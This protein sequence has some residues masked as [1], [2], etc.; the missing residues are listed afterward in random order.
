[1]SQTNNSSSNLEPNLWS[2]SLLVKDEGG[3]IHPWHQA[4]INPGTDLILSPVFQPAKVLLNDKFLAVEKS[5]HAKSPARHAFHP[6][7]EAEIQAMAANLPTDDSKKYSLEKIIDKLISKHN[8]HLLAE[9]HQIFS[10][11]FF[12]FFRNRKNA[13]VIREDLSRKISSD[14][15]ILSEEL[16]DILVGVAKVI[17]ENINK[18]AGL[19]VKEVDLLKIN[20]AKE[21]TKKEPIKT[22]K[23]DLPV[24]S[25]AN[26][27]ELASLEKELNAAWNQKGEATQ[28]EIENILHDLQP[29]SVRGGSLPTGQAG[30]SDGK[31]KVKT[32]LEAAPT[33][34]VA[35]KIEPKVEIKSQEPVLAHV[36]LPK[37][38]RSI[39][40]E[41]NRKTMTDVLPKA[42]VAPVT[43]EPVVESFVAPAKA[44]VNL[45]GPVEELSAMT[46]QNFR[47]LASGPAE[48]A[49]K[50][51]AKIAL[52]E[53][54][55]VTKKAQGI[56]AWRNSE[57]YRLYL[58]L[59]EESLKSAKN[60]AAIIKSRLDNNQETLSV[61]EFAA[62]SDLNKNL[63]F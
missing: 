27:P 51:L 21:Q 15:N 23:E 8:L 10:D 25:S 44:P 9:H 11:I 2:D 53:K 63:R 56:E 37:V 40:T 46:L 22:A 19:V 31:D 38:S 35:V 3:Q 7:D 33:A 58:D 13:I 62:I 5:G 16:I 50:I 12:D 42:P 59:G 48:Q 45:T 41:P 4:N 52:L 32:K 1:M 28:T 30:A 24:V 54:D 6:D 39:Q 29:A 49:E 43:P 57:V 34:P 20:L 18:S 60:I 26:Q 17:K 36:S 61:E 14:K 55:S 47:R